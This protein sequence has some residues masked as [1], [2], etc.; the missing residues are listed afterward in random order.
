MKFADSIILIEVLTIYS[1]QRDRMVVTEFSDSLIYDCG[2]LHFSDHDYD[3]RLNHCHLVGRQYFFIVNISA[4][5]GSIHK[6][7]NIVIRTGI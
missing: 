3:I 7:F 5:Q 4:F 6:P 2:A 1:I